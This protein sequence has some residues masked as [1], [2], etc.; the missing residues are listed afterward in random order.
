LAA[1]ASQP[2]TELFLVFF[3]FVFDKEPEPLDEIY[4]STSLYGYPG[5]PGALEQL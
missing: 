4:L 2:C 5:R 1:H 3:V